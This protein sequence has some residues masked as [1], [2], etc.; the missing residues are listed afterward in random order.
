[1][2]PLPVAGFI[3]IRSQLGLIE[4]SVPEATMRT[5]S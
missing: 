3:E 4:L 2:P 1:V 5:S